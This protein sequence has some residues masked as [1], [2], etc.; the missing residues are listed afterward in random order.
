M[1]YLNYKISGTPYV[2]TTHGGDIF[3]LQGKLLTHIKKIT[4]RNAKKITVVS[5]AIKKEIHD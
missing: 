5:T 3:G 2:V 4:L 1:A